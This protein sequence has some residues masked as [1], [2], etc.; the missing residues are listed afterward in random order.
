MSYVRN[1]LVS[2]LLSHAYGQGGTVAVPSSDPVSQASVAPMGEFPPGIGPMLDY[3]VSRYSAW[4]ATSTEV[5]WCFL[6]G[7]PGNGKLVITH[8]SAANCKNCDVGGVGVDCVKLLSRSGLLSRWLQIL[9]A[10]LRLHGEVL[11]PRDCLAAIKSPHEE[12]AFA[13]FLERASWCQPFN[14]LTSGPCPVLVIVN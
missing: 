1:P 14:R 8:I 5:D 3:L 11:S 13:S 9:R 2:W 6:V 10:V 12:R 4:G 7:G